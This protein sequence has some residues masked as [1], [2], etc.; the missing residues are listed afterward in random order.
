[1]QRFTPPRFRRLQN[2]TSLEAAKLL[3]GLGFELVGQ[4]DLNPRKYTVNG[5]IEARFEK[6][7]QG[8]TL[9]NV[10]GG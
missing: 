8:A 4:G 3:W 9:K 5:P 1:M 2:H 7:F 10:N 6:A